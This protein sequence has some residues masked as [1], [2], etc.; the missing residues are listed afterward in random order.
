MYTLSNGVRALA[1]AGTLLLSCLSANAATEP[2]RAPMRTVT[3]V[4]T[5]AINRLSNC[6]V[7]CAPSTRKTAL[8]PGPLLAAH[9]QR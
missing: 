2:R 3:P 9:P 4:T 1:F 7:V 8:E 5:K 6:I